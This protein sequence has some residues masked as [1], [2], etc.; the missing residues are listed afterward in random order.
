M[1]TILHTISHS[2]T[3]PLC[4]AMLLSE[5]QDCIPAESL[6]QLV[7][8]L[9]YMIA[10]PLEVFEVRQGALKTNPYTT[11]GWAG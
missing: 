5:F 11:S 10:N 9:E 3:L 7:S 8:L 2:L 6:D 4:C 1:L